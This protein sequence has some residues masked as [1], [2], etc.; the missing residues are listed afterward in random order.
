MSSVILG[1]HGYSPY[2]ARSLFVCWE[3]LTVNALSPVVTDKGST[4]AAGHWKMERLQRK[5]DPRS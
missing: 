3:I 5:T 1:S 4:P 2:G